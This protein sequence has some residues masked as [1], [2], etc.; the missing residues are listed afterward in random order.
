MECSRRGGS[1]TLKSGSGRNS[2]C[3]LVVDVNPGCC[4]EQ[5][6][7]NLPGWLREAFPGSQLNVQVFPEVSA[8][9]SPD[10]VFL[11]SSGPDLFSEA[12][13]FI[14][15]KWRSTPIVAIFCNGWDQPRD[16]AESFLS[17]LDDFLTCPFI[18]KEI[19]LPA[20]VWRLLQ[21][22]V[23]NPTQNGAKTDN[24]P[25]EKLVGD[26]VSFHRAIKKIPVLAS[27][28]AT[29][30]ICGETGTGKELVA[31][32]IHDQSARK[33]RAFVPVNCGALPDNVFENELFGHAKG[34]FTD[35]SSTERGLVGEAEG[36]TIFLDEVDSLSFSAQVK[37]LRFL[38]NGEYRPLGTSRSIIANVRII[39]A[40]N[41][42]LK[43]EVLERRFREDMYYRLTSLSIYLPPLRERIEDIPLLATYFLNRYASQYTRQPLRLSSSALQKLIAYSWPGNVRE[44]EGTLQ[45]AVVLTSTSILQPEDIDLPVLFKNEVTSSGPFRDAKA[46][47]IRH[48]ERSYLVDLLAEARGNITIAARRAG[49][50]RRT[51]QRLLQKYG[52]QRKCFA[53]SW[54][55][56]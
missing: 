16:V 12:L 19:E 29:A 51:F 3:F 36:G 11:R 56:D 42:D 10:I 48:F 28:D 22:K 6:C 39:A 5:S 17:G 41:V 24:F 43:R 49:K 2:Y 35:A 54:P 32:E 15:K 37:L 30:L 50:D 7:G 1:V 31:R 33:E 9:Y 46:E 34:A 27:S 55:D 52:L 18:N 23:I 53:S 40:T 45:R 44:L 14:K 20:R 38:Q 4:P 26:S 25:V 47:A 8:T 21:T 13:F